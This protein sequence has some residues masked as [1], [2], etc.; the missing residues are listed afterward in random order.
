MFRKPYPMRTVSPILLS[1]AST[2]RRRA[3]A[4][5][6]G[7]LLR[8]WQ[9]PDQGMP[10]AEIP[11]Q[12]ASRNVDRRVGAGPPEG[13]RHHAQNN[14]RGEG[15]RRRRDDGQ[16]RRGAGGRRGYG[17]EAPRPLR[18]KAEAF[19]RRYQMPPAASSRATSMRCA[20]RAVAYRCNRILHS[21]KKNATKNAVIVRKR[22]KPQVN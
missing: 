19:R 18:L 2:L 1:M 12:G 11:V 5:R 21:S 8:A 14:R 10:D 22:R 9:M 20:Q 7:S 13:Q 6:R 15:R 4:H 17:R 16:E 3:E